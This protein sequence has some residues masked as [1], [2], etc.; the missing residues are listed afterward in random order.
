MGALIDSHIEVIPGS[1][2]LI[3]LM[4]HFVIFNIVYAVCVSDVSDMCM[5]SMN[6][7]SDV[8][9]LQLHIKKSTL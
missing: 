8:R 9:V 7:V 4:Y 1:I 6:D 5:N 3:L 2:D